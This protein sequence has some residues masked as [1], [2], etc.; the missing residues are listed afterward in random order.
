MLLL[1]AGGSQNGEL[2][3]WKKKEDASSGAAPQ[4]DARVPLN[5]YSIE[6][7]PVS[8]DGKYFVFKIVLDTSAVDS[9]S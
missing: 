5:K 4:K 1:S 8:A 9:G 3:W 7:S 6:A 2:S